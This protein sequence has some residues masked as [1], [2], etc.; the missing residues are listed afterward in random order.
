MTLEQD[1][2][3]AI[4]RLE[5]WQTQYRISLGGIGICVAVIFFSFISWMSAP[6][7][8]DTSGESAV[9]GASLVVGVVFIG[10][11]LLA[12]QKMGD[13][14]GQ[15]NSINQDIRRRK[16]TKKRKRTQERKRKNQEQKRK[17]QEQKKNRELKEAKR[18]MEKGGIDNL[19]RAIGIFEKYGKK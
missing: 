19:N 7:L 2:A 13:A 1:L 11:G 3:E 18:L 8:A 10:Y 5:S 4:A 9:C 6:L 14:A 15:V 17:D 12:E 16:G